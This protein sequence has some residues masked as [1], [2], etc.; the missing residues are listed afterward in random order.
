MNRA[1]RK[2]SILIPETQILMEGENTLA[3]QGLNI[4]LEST[5][6]LMNVG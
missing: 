1:F 2:F 4:S 6:F 5:D 3:V